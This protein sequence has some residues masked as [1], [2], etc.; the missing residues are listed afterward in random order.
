MGK[1]TYK[2]T[3]DVYD[4]DWIEDKKEGDGRYE[5]KEGDVYVGRFKNDLKEG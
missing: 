1:F 4:G 5:Y 3:G 2:N